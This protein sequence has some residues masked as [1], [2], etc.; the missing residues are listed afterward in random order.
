MADGNTPKKACL[1]RKPKAENPNDYCR[2]CKVS[3]EVRYGDSWKSISCESP[4]NKK[5]GLNGL[6]CDMR[7]KRRKSLLGEIVVFLIK[8]LTESSSSIVFN[9]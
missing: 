7:Y 2:S 3:F 6:S 8:R 9:L 5:K 4:S 1:G